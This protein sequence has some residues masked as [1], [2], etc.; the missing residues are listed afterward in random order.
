M[1]V[2]E[3]YSQTIA[4]VVKTLN[5]KF[6]EVRTKM[7]LKH[8]LQSNSHNEN[9]PLVNSLMRVLDDF[10]DKLN[11]KHNDHSKHQSVE[12]KQ[13]EQQMDEQDLKMDIK[14]EKLSSSDR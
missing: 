8:S 9:M 4:D 6:I 1:K 14:M 13:S 3:H 7:Y 11:L 5:S 12:T 2:N 10:E